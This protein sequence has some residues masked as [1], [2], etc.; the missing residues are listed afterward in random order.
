MR[1][2]NGWI[3]SN[4]F[5]NSKEKFL[6]LNRRLILAAQNRGI[7]LTHYSNDQL[8]VQFENDGLKLGISKK[9]DFVIFMDKDVQLAKALEQE[10]FRLFNSAKAIEICDD[11]ALTAMAVSGKGIKLPRTVLAPK[12]FEGIGYSNLEFL[13]SV[14]IKLGLPLVVKECFGSFGQQVYLAND[15]EGLQQIVSNTSKPL[16]FQEYISSS[17]GRDIRIQ[18]VGGKVVASMLR[19]NKNDFRANITNGAT[20]ESYHPSVEECEMALKVCEI[21]GVDFAGV[22]ILFGKEGPVF[23]E[24]NSNAHIENIFTCTGIDVAESIIDYVIKEVGE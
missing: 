7:Q 12:T 1:N 2:L 16:L 11:K 21:I 10:G 18:V 20:M 5:L 23:C 17:Y 24:I 15:L 19:V 13:E 8:M 3:I 14:I 4:R 9:L 22:D 6:Q